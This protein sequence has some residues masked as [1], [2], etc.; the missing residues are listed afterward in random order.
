ML[1]FKLDLTDYAR[2][3]LLAAIILNVTGNSIL[4]VP[5]ILILNGFF[6]L[7]LNKFFPYIFTLMAWAFIVGGL[8]GM[9]LTTL[10]IPHLWMYL[11]GYQGLGYVILGLFL[12]FSQKS[13]II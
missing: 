6:Y 7:C 10:S 4:I 5:T 12:K 11:V 3:P 13:N 1:H 9:Y 8:V 2:I